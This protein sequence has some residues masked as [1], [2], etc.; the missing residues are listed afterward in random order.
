[1]AHE[2][3]AIRERKRALG[4]ALADHRRAAGL[5]QR[6]IAHRVHYTRTAVS[7]AEA[8][9]HLPTRRFWADADDAVDAD[10]ALLDHFDQVRRAIGESERVQ[11]EREQTAFRR[12]ARRDHS[13]YADGMAVTGAESESTSDDEAQELAAAL[14]SARRVGPDVVALFAAQL[15]QIRTL[16]RRL[17]GGLVRD[18]VRAKI[19]QIEPLLRHS[20]DPATR[21]SLAT[22][23]TEYCTLAGWQ[24]LDNGLLG[25]AWQHYENAKTAARESGN[26]ALFAHVIAEQ[27]FVLIDIGRTVDAAEVT[28]HALAAARQSAPAILLAWLAAAHGEALAADERPAQSLRAF[29]RAGRALPAETVHAETPYV[30]MNDVHLTRWRGHALARCGERSAVTVL[31]DALQALDPSFTRAETALRVDLTHALLHAGER[32]SAVEQAAQARTLAGQVGS[33]RQRRRLARLALSG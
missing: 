28:G 31:S 19:G 30:A 5:S 9:R 13:G 6:E 1:M 4:R 29:D 22:V 20:V 12:R 27:A 7:H 3:D 15:A 10:G 18:E 2:T 21:R 33:V 16:D 8:G 26:A 25:E 23:L 11:R 17:G 32:D 24:C 14:H